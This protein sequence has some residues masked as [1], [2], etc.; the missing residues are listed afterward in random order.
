MIDVIL[1]VILGLVAWCVASEGVVGAALTLV[2]VVFAGLLA[3]NVFEPLASFLERTISLGPAWSYRWDFLALMGSFALFV[4][5]LRLMC[6]H[7]SPTFVQTQ[8]LVHDIGR[9][10]CGL[11][12]GYV[13]IAFLLTALH[14]APLPRVVSKAGTTEFLG[15][16]A[17]RSNFF[18]MAPDRQ[19]LGFTQHVSLGALRRGRPFDGPLY[20]RGD[21]HGE[22]GEPLLWPSFPLR[23]AFRREQIA[24]GRYSAGGGAAPAGQ[25]ANPSTG[26]APSSPATPS[27]F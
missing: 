18:G 12:T 24:T 1:L 16:R 25:P 2:S 9:W 8:Q 27:P 26:P 10:A 17:E 6:E 13:T 11:L 21:Y 5:L 15:F 14:T 3:I 22:K 7:L 19:W 23:Y 4:F 20:A